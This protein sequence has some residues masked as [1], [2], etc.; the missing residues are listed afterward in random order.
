MYDQ[1]RKQSAFHLATAADDVNGDEETEEDDE[2]EGDA[3]NT[4]LSMDALGELAEQIK[5]A[6]GT[7]VTKPG[8][9]TS[10]GLGDLRAMM[11]DFDMMDDGLEIY[12]N[13]SDAD[14]YAEIDGDP[15]AISFADFSNG[16]STQPRKS[17]HV[18]VQAELARAQ[19]RPG[20]DGDS[21]ESMAL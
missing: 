18:N 12:H 8:R 21:D 2:E 19:T 13:G 17:M 6:R 4:P 20:E 11:A 3:E 9:E 14:E 16:G 15:N 10:D 7:Q 1:G 5:H